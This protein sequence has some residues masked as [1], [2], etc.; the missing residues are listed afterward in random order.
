ML[1]PYDTRGIVHEAVRETLCNLGFTVD[2]PHSLQQDMAYLRHARLGSD[3][4]AKWTK[5]A[6]VSTF[7]S[8]LGFALWQGI[9]QL[10]EVR[11]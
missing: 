5:R 2:D 9:R 10:M 8:G 6:M 4:I 1:Q 7:I 11:G 3:E